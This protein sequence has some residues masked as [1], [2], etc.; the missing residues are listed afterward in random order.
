MH[1][2]FSNSDE[3][4]CSEFELDCCCQLVLEITWKVMSNRGRIVDAQNLTKRIV[5][6][7]FFL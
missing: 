6:Y 2:A 1:C 7:S 4:F 5:R 3:L